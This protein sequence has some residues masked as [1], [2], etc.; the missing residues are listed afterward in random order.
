MTPQEIIHSFEKSL[1]YAARDGRI[2]T[3]EISL[4]T[5]KSA[6]AALH[7]D[8]REWVRG[9][10]DAAGECDALH[11]KAQWFIDHLSDENEAKKLAAQT[12][13]VCNDIK[14]RIQKLSTAPASKGVSEADETRKR[15]EDERLRKKWDGVGT[16]DWKGLDD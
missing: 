6:I 5:I 3:T 4:D 14:N 1:E 13:L 11:G 16:K 9:L 15:A 8:N 10:E 7:T 12:Q 2:Y